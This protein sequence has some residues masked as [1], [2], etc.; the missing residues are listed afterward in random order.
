MHLSYG[1]PQ[2]HILLR[3]RHEPH[4]VASLGIGSAPCACPAAEVEDYSTHACSGI[5]SSDTAASYGFYSSFHMTPRFWFVS[6][7]APTWKPRSRLSRRITK[8]SSIVQSVEIT[9]S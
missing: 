5:H 6:G 3:Q 7:R 1:L 4:V 8:A 2:T 9:S